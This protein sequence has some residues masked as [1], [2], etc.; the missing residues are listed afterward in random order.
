M[1]D[2]LSAPALRKSLPA[3]FRSKRNVEIVLKC[4]IENGVIGPPQVLAVY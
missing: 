1:G 2:L 3:N 4:A